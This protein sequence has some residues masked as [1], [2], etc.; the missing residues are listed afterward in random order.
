MRDS[1]DLNCDL[2]E[3]DKITSSSLEHRLMPLIST[4]NVACG[5]HAGNRSVMESVIRLAAEHRVHVGAHISYAD[6]NN[7]RRVS[8]NLAD[9]EFERLV[10]SQIDR[11]LEVC[12]SLD[13]SPPMD[14]VKLHGALYH[15]VGNDKTLAVRFVELLREQFSTARPN[16]NGEE[17]SRHLPVVAMAGSRL[18][19]VC[20]ALE[21]PC[22][23][24]AFAD[25]R[26]NSALQLV[27]RSNGVYAFLSA[28]EAVEQV[29]MLLEGKVAT[30]T[31]VA[32]VQCDSVCIHSDTPNALQLANAVSD[33]LTQM[34]V[35]IGRD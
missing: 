11:M 24:E 29:A 4:C 17:R 33:R 8:M 12:A 6:R 28:R 5:E 2:G 22:L 15:D 7:F 13:P 31:G 3:C 1:I 21:H 18:S 34:G 20:H 10:I 25:R 14:H 19:E 26:Y 32:I 9:G 16:E 27:P 35:R 23:H 30:S